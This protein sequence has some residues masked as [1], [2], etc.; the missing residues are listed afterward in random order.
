M[1]SKAQ[2]IANRI[3]ARKS[4]GPRTHQGKSI[5]SQNALKHGLSAAKTI[6]ADEDPADFALHREQLLAEFSPASPLE[7]ILAERLVTLSWRL[8]RASRLQAQTL[9]A[10]HSENT[11]SPLSNIIKSIIPND[12]SKKSRRNLGRT[13]IKDFSDSRV[14]ERLLMYERRIEHSLYKTIL[15]LQRLNLIRNM[16]IKKD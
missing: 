2:L 5:V 13:I 7:S 4:T 16:N 8:I 15:E 3:N 14:L 1:A 10:L 11:N 9:N 6:T 12:P